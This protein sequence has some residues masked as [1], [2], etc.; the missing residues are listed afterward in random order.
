MDG[1]THTGNDLGGHAP[2]GADGLQAGWPNISRARAAQRVGRRLIM[3]AVTPVG[4]I[5]QGYFV[6]NRE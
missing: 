5:S 4:D 1:D 6:Q 3:A 2:H